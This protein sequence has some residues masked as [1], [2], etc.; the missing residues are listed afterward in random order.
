MIDLHC[1]ILPEVDDGPA[2]LDF[3]LALGRA[4]AAAGIQVIVATPHIRSD[5]PLDPESVA[6][7]AGRLSEEVDAAGIP[8][9]ILSGGE[10]AAS[11]LGT[12]S[13]S[14][15]EQVALGSSSCV[16]VECPGGEDSGFERSVAALRD[17]GFVALL[18]HPE[19]SRMFQVD[20]RRLKRLIEAGALCSVTAS[21]VA[22]L[23]GRDARRLALR[24]LRDDLVHDVASDAHDHVHRSIDL[25]G[26]LEHAEGEIPGLSAQIT[27]LTDAAPRAILA[28]QALPPRPVRA[29]SRLSRWYRFATGSPRSVAPGVDC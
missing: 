26:V 23:F 12:L 19:R 4:A 20:Y 28:D 5:F 27:W 11:S 16:L 10:V 7:R 29:P 1:H 22:G 9:R 13:D 18:A 24:L 6:E 17:R 25:R 14:V 3:S 8:L 21:S 15:L 2:N